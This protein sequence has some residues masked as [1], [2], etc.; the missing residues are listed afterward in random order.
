MMLVLPSKVLINF[1]RGCVGGFKLNELLVES[2]LKEIVG[3]ISLCLYDS[4]ARWDRGFLKFGWLFWF[5]SICG[6]TAGTI[7]ASFPSTWFVKTN[8]TWNV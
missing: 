3:D 8:E 6:L 1:E 5:A 7:G 4:T 2:P